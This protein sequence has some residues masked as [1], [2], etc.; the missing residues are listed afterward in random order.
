MDDEFKTCQFS[1]N[2]EKKRDAA[3][4]FDVWRTSVVRSVSGFDSPVATHE[5][6]RSTDPPV[7]RIG[8]NVNVRQDRQDGFPVR[9]ARATPHAPFRRR[10]DSV[11]IATNA[12]VCARRDSPCGPA[13]GSRGAGQRDAGKR[14][15]T[16]RLTRVGV[17][18]RA[19][20]RQTSR[21]RARAAARREL[22]RTREMDGRGA[23]VPP[24]RASATRGRVGTRARDSER[25]RNARRTAD[26]S[27][28]REASSGRR[29]THLCVARQAQPRGVRA[30]EHQRFRRRAVVAGP[31][32][33][34]VRPSRARALGGVRVLHGIRGKCAF[35]F[36][37]GAERVRGK[38]SRA[39]LSEKQSEPKKTNR[40]SGRAFGFATETVEP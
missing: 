16:S 20:A 22:A 34:G 37:A 35:C 40:L 27:G 21:P 30:A 39:R 26:D 13:R 4:V 2:V 24:E 12:R 7:G 38:S 17:N 28:R 8:L 11:R 5:I 29:E 31:A 19:R 14:K 36:F 15:S 3:F 33:V 25:A 23:F 32:H 6:A 10:C 9:R 18:K 1:S